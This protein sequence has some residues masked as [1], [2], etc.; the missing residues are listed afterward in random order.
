MYLLMGFSQGFLE[1]V[2]ATLPPASVV[3][4]EEPD[5]IADRGLSDVARSHACVADL[6]PSPY[7]ES[8]DFLQ[9]AWLRDQIEAVVPGHEYA[10][11]ATARLA[12]RLGR[13]G[14]GAAA[15]AT[16]RS[17]LRLRAVARQAGIRSPDWLEIH[18][19]RDIERFG[20]GGPVVVKP[21]GRQAS[22]G[23]Q[24]LAN[25]DAATATAA[26]HA[27]LSDDEV[28]LLP[29]RPLTKRFLVEDVLHGRE[30]SAEALVR[31]GTVVFLNITEKLVIGG[32][33]PVEAGHAVPAAVDR[34]TIDAFTASMAALVEALEFSTGVLHAEWMLT[35]DG[36]ALIEC[37]GRCPGD[38][39]TDL[40]DLAWDTRFRLALIN[41]LAGRPVT[42]PTRPARGSAI[43]FLAPAT[44]TVVR[45]DGVEGARQTRG[46]Q[47]VHLDVAEGS[48]T[49]QWASSWDRPGYV[50]VTARDGGAA[51]K[52]AEEVAARVQI[53]VTT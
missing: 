47:E 32:V 10:V 20:R 19:A 45:I 36:L 6:V 22:V 53:V 11:S 5:V 16:L 52:L 33:R 48:Q 15:G 3:V 23:V 31:S 26:W 27:L 49:R 39:I 18:E 38:R 42:L 8:D 35:T 50:I 17:K 24:V 4:V 41:L 1:A 21:D 44:G 13:P 37:A 46:V 9:I 25:S 40:I 51:R 28:G 30:F 29:H 14:C 12:I 2:S 7:H 34:R 43:R